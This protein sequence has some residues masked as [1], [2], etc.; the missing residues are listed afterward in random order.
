MLPLSSMF[1]IS[2]A[3]WKLLMMC[4]GPRRFEKGSWT[5][6]FVKGLKKV[7]RFCVF[8]FKRHSVSSAKTYTGKS[9]FFSAEGYCK[10]PSCTV[11]FRLLMFEKKKVLVKF[12]GLFKHPIRIS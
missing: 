7:N 1:V 10:I 5:N 2:D 12:L 11:E 9:P 8:G 6:I 3:D 4:K